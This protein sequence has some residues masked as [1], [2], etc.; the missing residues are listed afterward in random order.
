M[1]AVNV[2]FKPN[3]E[4]N[5]KTDL[6]VFTC[7]HFVH[8]IVAD[9]ETPCDRAVSDFGLS[10]SALSALSPNCRMHMIF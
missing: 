3:L 1:V 10:E 5:T 4:Y 2:T 9:R 6:F 7:I 8:D